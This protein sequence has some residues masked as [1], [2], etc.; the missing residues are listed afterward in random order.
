M[1]VTSSLRTCQSC[2][3]LQHTR[4]G[5]CSK[6]SNEY[7][8]AIILIVWKLQCGSTAPKERNDSFPCLSPSLQTQ[9]KSPDYMQLVTNQIFLRVFTAAI[10]FCKSLWQNVCINPSS[11]SAIY[12]LF[13]YCHI[14]WKENHIL[15]PFQTLWESV[16]WW[17]TFFFLSHI[18]PKYVQRGRGLVTADR[19]PCGKKALI[20]V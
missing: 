12:L 8:E 14:L 3:S 18:Y 16:L 6:Y 13:V 5:I 11:H 20:C 17:W 15:S 19:K 7:Q 1:N 2:S 4:L 9:I 10:L